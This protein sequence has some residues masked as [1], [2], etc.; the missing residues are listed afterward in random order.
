MDPESLRK[1]IRVQTLQTIG[2]D[3]KAIIKDVGMSR[4]FV[5]KWMK[6]DFHE[7]LPRSGRPTKITTAVRKTV[8]RRLSLKSK[9]HSS[10]SLR[11]VAEKV[12]LHHTTVRNIRIDSGLKPYLK[13][14][15]PIHRTITPAKRLKFAKKR[16]KADWSK[17]IFVD[18]KKFQLYALGNH[19][20]DVVYVFDK[21]NVPVQVQVAHPPKVN[22][23][24]RHFCER[25]CWHRDFRGELDGREVQEDLVEDHAAGCQKTL[26]EQEIHG[27]SR[28]RPETSVQNCSAVVRGRED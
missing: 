7:D 26:S 15:E 10:E 14:L 6:R 24:A 23:W 13:T 16:A 20:N 25:N 12:G 4:G 2:Y 11:Q 3:E 17:Y 21:E 22:V 18:E 1:R 27:S 28:R 5:R 19:H 9:T 8:V